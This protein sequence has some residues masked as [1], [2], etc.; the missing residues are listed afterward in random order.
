MDWRRFHP[1]RSAALRRLREV[2]RQLR[3][4][5]PWVWYGAGG[6]TLLFVLWPLLSL[7]VTGLCVFGLTFLAL[8]GGRALH[9]AL[10]K[11]AAKRESRARSQQAGQ[12]R[13]TDPKV[14]I[15]WPPA[16]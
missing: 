2:A 16:P 1:A 4:Q 8:V 3:G 6:A 15:L 9:R 5:P 7:I 11:M 13:S 12:L 10:P 14:E